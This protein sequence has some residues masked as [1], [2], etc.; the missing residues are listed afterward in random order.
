MPK[1]VQRADASDNWHVKTR[2]GQATKVPGRSWSQL[3]KMCTKT[4]NELPLNWTAVDA[5]GNAALAFS[6]GEIIMLNV[7]LARAP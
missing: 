2:Q 7:M 1:V 4:C 6:D 5:A 3:R